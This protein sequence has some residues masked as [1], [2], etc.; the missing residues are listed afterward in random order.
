MLHC[1][2][3]YLC[4]Y[5]FFITLGL[6]DTLTDPRNVWYVCVYVYMYIYGCMLRLKV[7]CEHDNVLY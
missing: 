4:I 5:D 6:Y 3:V 7:N 1:T 2:F